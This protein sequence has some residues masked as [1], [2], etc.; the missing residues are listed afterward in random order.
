VIDIE[1][2]KYVLS[3]TADILEKH[4]MKY[5][6]DSGTLLGPYRDGGLIPYDHDVDIRV[7]PNQIDPENMGEFILDFWQAG[8]RQI[9]PNY[10]KLSEIIFMSAK[11]TMLDL[12]FAYQDKNWLW[13]YCYE[14][15]F[16][17]NEPRVHCY[18]R[19]FF[20]KMTTI[21]VYGR[22]YPAPAPIEKYLEYHYGEWREFK[23]SAYQAGDTDLGWD[24]L[25]G[26][27]CALSLKELAEKRNG[28]SPG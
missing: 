24:Y 15:P 9:L 17:V 7:L 14:Q 18:P 3:V 13:I 1:D 27:P 10:G 19:K 12:K 8:F 5:W 23:K 21:E 6:L 4:K 11:P 26:P 16:D 20:N 2:A 28:N 22:K 25:H